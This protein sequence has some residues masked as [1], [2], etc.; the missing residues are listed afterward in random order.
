MQNDRREDAIQH[1][2][3]AFNLLAPTGIDQARLSKMVREMRGEA[4]TDRTIC[5]A[6][7]STLYDGLQYAN[8]PSTLRSR[9]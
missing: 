4:E 3:T 1:L 6:I 2:M 5:K 9:S 8:W 7:A